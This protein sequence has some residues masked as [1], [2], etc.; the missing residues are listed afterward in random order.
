MISHIFLLSGTPGTGKTSIANLITEKYHVPHLSL[1]EIVLTH[2][3][4]SEEDV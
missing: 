1:T 2:Q 4:F 3:L